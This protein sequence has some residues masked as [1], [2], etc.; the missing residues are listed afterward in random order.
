MNRRMFLGAVVAAPV[1]TVVPAQAQ[2]PARFTVTEA[3]QAFGVPLFFFDLVEPGTRT[4]WSTGACA[5][6]VLFP[7]RVP[8]TLASAD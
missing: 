5:S 6:G 2:T 7:K 4:G 1:A 8:V 3:A